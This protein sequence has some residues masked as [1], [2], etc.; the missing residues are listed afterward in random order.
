MQAQKS[1]DVAV[2]VDPGKGPAE[3]EHTKLHNRWHP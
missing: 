1:W 3:Q 2:K